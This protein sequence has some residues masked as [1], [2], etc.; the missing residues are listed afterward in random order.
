METLIKINEQLLNA[1]SG[2]LVM[3]FA[4]AIGYVCKVV[5]FFPNN[6][7]PL[8]VVSSCSVAF[9]LLTYCAETDASDIP[10]NFIIGFVLGF[11]AWLFHAQI[12]KRFV[13]PK[14]FNQDPE[15]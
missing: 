9:P 1:P 5:S 12:L 3:A 15:I 6:R 8:V 2:V 14:L 11:I 4:I 13:D 10:R 7:I